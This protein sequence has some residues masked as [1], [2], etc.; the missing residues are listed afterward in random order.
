MQLVVQATPEILVA[1]WIQEHSAV[2]DLVSPQFP[3]TADEASQ[4]VGLFPLLE[5]NQVHQEHIVTAVQ[6]YVIVQEIPQLPIVECLQEQFVETIEVAPQERVTQR[7]SEQIQVHVNT[8]STST[9]EQTMDIP[10][11]R[12][13]EETGDVSVQLATHAINDCIQ[14]LKLSKVKVTRL[15]EMSSRVRSRLQVLTKSSGSRHA[16][17]QAQNEWDLLEAQLREAQQ[18]VHDK[19]QLLAEALREKQHLLN[20][21]RR[22]LDI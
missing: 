10:V 4:V 1:E 7:T 2:T 22:R 13:V 6:P 20:M 9:S 18:F 8:S 3:I 12:G 11:H 5:D 19:K 21:K 15:E 17:R 14:S 16:V